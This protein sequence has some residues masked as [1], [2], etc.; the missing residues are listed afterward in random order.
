[1]TADHATGEI[2]IDTFDDVL[3]VIP[4]RYR[5][6]RLP[7]KPLVPIAGKPMVVRTAEQVSKAVP[8]ERVIVATDDE[9]IAAVCREHG[10]R[11]EMT[12]DEHATGGDRVAEVASRI[13]AQIYVNVQGDEPVFNPNDVLAA[14]AA[15][16]ADPSKTYLG[17]CEITDEEQWRDSKYLKLLF[18]EKRNL[19]YIGRAQVPGSHDGAFHLGYRGVWVYAYSPEGLAAFAAPGHR[20][21]LELIEDCEV[22]RFLELGLPVEVVPMSADSISVDRPEDVAKVE[23]YLAREVRSDRMSPRTVGYGRTEMGET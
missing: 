19:Y 10:I 9:R 22:V 13:P 20:T 7:G 21:R 18:G 2:A 15:A 16:R 4:A 12:N 14:I 6:S 23:A 17:Y 3:V 5:S 8:R 1:M 11:V